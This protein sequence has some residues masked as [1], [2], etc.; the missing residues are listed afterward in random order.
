MYERTELEAFV[1]QSR[2]QSTSD[3]PVQDVR[4]LQSRVSS[5]FGEDMK[6]S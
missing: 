4:A 1:A 6:D 5:I 3:Q 2:R